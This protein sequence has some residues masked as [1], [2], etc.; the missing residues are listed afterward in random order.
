MES[1]QKAPA[2]SMPG[3]AGCTG[4]SLAS[5][6]EGFREETDLGF[7]V[8]NYPP[9]IVEDRYVWGGARVESC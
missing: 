6:S 9:E 7:S 2:L 4:E 8:L 5:A 3:W 1:D